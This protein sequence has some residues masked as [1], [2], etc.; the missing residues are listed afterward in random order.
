MPQNLYFGIDLGTTNS[1]AAW[2]KVRADGKFITQ[3]VELRVLDEKKVLR[4][5][6]ILPSCVY[7]SPRGEPPIVG[8]YARKMLSTQSHRVV[9]SAKSYM[10]TDKTFSPDDKPHTP[11]EISSI[12]LKQIAISAKDFN[13]G[14]VPDDAV[15]TVPASFDPDQRQDTND[16]A[17][18]AGFRVSEDDGRPRNIL[19]NEPAAALYDFLNRQDTGETPEI[20][21]LSSPKVILVFDL[22]GGTLDV[23]LHEVTRNPSGREGT[24]PYDIKPYAISRHTLLGGDD[25]DR[26]LQKFF[27]D[28]LEGFDIDSLDPSRADLFRSE[29]LEEAEAAKIA[30]SSEVET[31]RMQGADYGN[32]SYDVMMNFI[33][34][35][36]LTFDYVLTVEEY[37]QVMTPYL[38]PDL[39]MKSLENFDAL[40]GRTEN[41]I[42]PV[43]DVLNKARLKLG[44]VPK[45]DAVLLN[46]G[47]SKLFA[48]RERIRDFFG[49]DPLEVGDPDLAVARG[50]SVYHYWRHLGV[51]TPEIQND[52]IGIGIQ[53]GKVHKLI[54]AGTT[55]PYTTDIFEFAIPENGAAFIDL[56]FYKGTRA[57][58]MPPNRRIASRRIRFNSPLPA[59]TPVDLQA[60][61]NE[62]GTMTLTVWNPEAPDIHYT[63]ENVHTD[64]TESY[65]APAYIAPPG[66]FV[67]RT[68]AAIMQ[69]GKTEDIMSLMR[70]YIKTGQDFA[71]NKFPM[72]NGMYTARLKELETRIESASNC[73]EAIDSMAGIVSSGGIIADRA[74]R[75]LG[76]LA[77]VAAPKYAAKA[78]RYLESFCA[79]ERVKFSISGPS[80]RK[81]HIIGME[82][83]ALSMMR[84]PEDEKRFLE[85]MKL[86]PFPVETIG[87]ELCYAL[88][89]TGHTK[90]SVLAVSKYITSLRVGERIPAYWALG[91]IA[92]RE[93]PDKCG[94]ACL[95][96][97]LPSM[98]KHLRKEEHCDI[99]RNGIY[100][101]GEMCDQRIPGEKVSMRI[102]NQAERFLE[103]LAE[104][105]TGIMKYSQAS[106]FLKTALNMIQGSELSAEQEEHLLKLRDS[107]GE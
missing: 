54:L 43:L 39:S 90:E 51:K 32:L 37:R 64:M 12:I 17:K 22:G 89:R 77:R 55:L 96:E 102:K 81:L 27:M 48:V 25:F 83:Q 24:L 30:L 94:A 70:Q 86:S 98:F 71:A 4:K 29:F 85:I 105:I 40:A 91:R 63:V 61:V 57:D 73:G 65:T 38:A 66:G 79:P 33:A 14:T 67:K 80:Q 50:A 9:K 52:D 19:L 7:F 8:E 53:D 78:A 45:I 21:D 5:K 100:A 1:V 88:G 68:P 34:N 82:I 11:A 58:I 60:T 74:A 106:S 75:M 36:P 97:I 26:L 62:A 6:T 95:E 20:L 49:F 41:I 15:I 56:P 42:Y 10:G 3:A 87:R 28:K 16:A 13:L 84:R 99:L 104:R 92:S 72:N 44:H 59:E 23:S 31:Y 69:T 2:G 107:Y 35:T 46:G 101:I 103:E 18:I 93:R 76:R 47:M